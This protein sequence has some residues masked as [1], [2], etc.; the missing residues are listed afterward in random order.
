MLVLLW[1]ASALAKRYAPEIGSDTVE[2]FF[3]AVPKA[4]MVSSS[5]SYVEIVSILLRKFNRGAIASVAF[6]AAKSALR[7]ELINDP[8]FVLLSIDDIAFYL[9]IA[10]M[11]AHNLNATDAAL[12]ILFQSYIQTFAPD[13]RTNFLLVAADERLVR[14]A[15]LEG[16][17]AI[18][19]E[20]MLAADVPAFLA[21]L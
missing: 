3:T 20:I 12:L 17:P 4:K 16:M 14:A 15:R 18:N 9:G 7:I 1:D 11:E 13:S 6:H 10:L 21:A 2:A 5:V 8:E 19:P